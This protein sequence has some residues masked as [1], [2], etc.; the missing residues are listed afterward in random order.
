MKTLLTFDYEVYFGERTGSVERCLLEPTDALARV[1]E[2]HG[3]PL[4]FF[5]DV[6]Y[7][8]AL[9]REMRRDA[10]LRLAHDAICRQLAALVRSGHELQLHVHPHWEDARWT[11]AE[12]KLDLARY[13]LHAFAPHEVGDIVR[14]YLEALRDV[15]GPTAGRAFRAGG[16]VIQPF[17]RLREALR[18]AGVAIDS[19]VYPGGHRGGNV[20]PYDFRGAP[21]RSRWR[22]EHDPLVEDASGYFLEV[23]I[24]SRE[25]KP[26]FFWRLALAKKAGGPYY[27]A[28]GDGRAIAMDGGDLANKLTK[29]ST[30]VV[31]LDGYKAS[32][33]E[34]AAEDY[35]SRGLED[36]VVIG[37]PKALSPFSLERLDQFLA[38]GK[39]GEL[40][41][42]SAYS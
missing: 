27:R 7:L 41:N 26:S 42:Y 18:L 38:G 6:G 13:A 21:A 33:V 34:D 28:Y 2:R 40:A 14:R 24:A 19:T 16:W 29:P 39:A 5:V 1:A 25:V 12:W 15:G 9:R 30:S 32:L 23:P 10:Q 36:F 3:A 35:R 4:V 31:S 22:F 8:L 20:Q 17:D 11:G 37:H